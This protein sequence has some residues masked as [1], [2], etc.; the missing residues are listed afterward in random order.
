MP[1]IF[2]KSHFQELKNLKGEKGAKNIIKS[3][4]KTV[5]KVKAS[6]LLTDI[7]TPK[8]YQELSKHSNHQF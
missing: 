3:L 2:H 5:V 7:D 4:D 6:N 8:V 1:A